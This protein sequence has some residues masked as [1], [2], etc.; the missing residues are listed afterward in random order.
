MYAARQVLEAMGYEV[1]EPKPD[2]RSVCCGRT[3]LAAGLVDQAKKEAARFIETVMPWIRQ[4]ISVVGLEP[5]C[6][7]TL[8]DEF[9]VLL[10]SDDATLLAKHAYLFEEFVEQALQEENMVL[11]L[12][13]AKCPEV[14]VHGHCHQKAARAM[15][16][17]ESLL[18]RIPGL[19]VSMIESSCCGMAGHFGYQTETAKAS[20]AMAELDLLPAVRSASSNA[21]IIADGTSCRHQ[22]TDNTARQAEHVAVLLAEH[23][24]KE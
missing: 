2:N 6:L 11:N 1:I 23:L 10:P 8:R 9:Q 14:L 18:Q 15:G 20:I 12:Q 17:V 22:I 7:L 13:P 3:F 5:S 21:R 19:K 24:R 4:G 16:P